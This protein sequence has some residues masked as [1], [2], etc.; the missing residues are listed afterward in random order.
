MYIDWRAVIV[1]QPPFG[2]N[3]SLP[4]RVLTLA[5]AALLCVFLSPAAAAHA[6]TSSSLTVV[7]TSDVSDSGLMQNLIQPKFN[8]AYPQ[9]TFKY[10]GTATGTAITDAE[11]GVQT[12]SVLIVHA[13]SLENQFVRSGYSYEQFGRAIFTNDFVLAGPS[14]GS[15]PA[16]VAANGAN[17]IVR[18][19]AD[20]AA[21]G[22]NGAG[23]PLATFI[24]RGGT[25]GTTV[26]EHQIWALVGALPSPP[27][28]LNLCTVSAADGGGMTP[29]SVASG[30]GGQPCG[31]TGLPPATA[32][33]SWYVTTGL[34]QGPNVVAANACTGYASPTG[35]SC[36][37]LT[38]RGTYDYLASGQDA[39][40]A[41][42]GLAIVTRGPQ[43]ASAPGGPDL[44]VNYFHAYIINPAK[45][46]ACGVNLPAAQDFVNFLTS[47]VVQSQLKTYL[48]GADSA[49]PPFVADASPNLTATGIPGVDKAGTPVAVTGTLTNAEPGYPPLANQTV[50]VDEIVA[51]VPVAVASAK[52]GA[53]GAY[54]ITFKPASSGSYQVSTGEIAQIENSTLTPPFGDLLSPAASAAVTMQ[55]AS[56]VSISRATSSPGGATVFGSVAPAP[57]DA[58]GT[59]TILARRRGSKAGFKTIG[60]TSLRTGQSSV[61]ATGALPV[62]KWQVKAKYEDPG[63]VLAAA[64]KALNVNVVSATSSVKFKTVTAKNGK[65]DVTGTVNPAPTGSG[66]RIEFFAVRTAVL[67]KTGTGVGSGAVREIAEATV[68]TGKTKFT[69]KA[70]VTPGYT[71]VLQLAYVRKGQTS[72]YSKLK[73]IDVN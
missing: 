54:S 34:T 43:S 13:A 32:L 12:A 16:G 67:T 37:V 70:T 6:D 60:A 26:E 38:D 64:T 52:T 18:A 55:V 44:L 73:T 49:G 42:P 3:Q 41:I 9:F 36:Y 2:P 35:K 1:A 58:K 61:A 24:S 69:I 4:R 33:P 51:G 23:P 20:I 53:N 45:C 19:F 10:V 59:V 65:L 72:S 56:T 30:L 25:P 15:D 28:G 71:W 31:A 14:G 22:N 29:V 66:A 68:A 7:G 50:S 63:Q 27:A 46:A 8:A 11:T 62:G 5:A 17:N 48:N 39:A 40:G 47:P 57:A 21:A